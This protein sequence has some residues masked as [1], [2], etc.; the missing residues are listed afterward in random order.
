MCCLSI[1]GSESVLLCH[2]VPQVEAQW[3]SVRGF[4]LFELLPRPPP[5]ED[6]SD[7]DSVE[8]TSITR[9]ALAEEEIGEGDGLWEGREWY[10]AKELEPA[11]GLN[12]D[13]QACA[14]AR[15]R[16]QQMHT[17]VTTIL[18][19]IYIMTHSRGKAVGGGGVEG[20][21]R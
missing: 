6:E 4:R 10:S 1:V 13:M 20:G 12:W 7:A 3:E 8:D 17:K 19:I 18:R 5:A 15:T 11:G 9:A 21:E 14:R 2:A 16:S